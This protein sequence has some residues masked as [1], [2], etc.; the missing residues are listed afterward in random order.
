MKKEDVFVKHYTPAASKAGKAIFNIKDF[1]QLQSHG[2]IVIGVIR[3]IIS[4]VYNVQYMP[5]TFF[6]G[7]K[8]YIYV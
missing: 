1:G 4:R 5:N 7:C 6:F 3:A 2:V 8:L